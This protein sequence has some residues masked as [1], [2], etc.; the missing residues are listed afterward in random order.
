MGKLTYFISLMLLCCAFIVQTNDFGL[1][2]KYIKQKSTS[3]IFVTS[4]EQVQLFYVCND[5]S[6]NNVIKGKSAKLEIEYFT[7]LDCDD[8]KIYGGKLITENIDSLIKDSIK[9]RF[10]TNNYYIYSNKI[11]YIQKMIPCCYKKFNFKKDKYLI[12]EFD[13]GVS[14]TKSGPKKAI[15]LFQKKN[16]IWNYIRTIYSNN[17][18]NRFA[19]F[20]NDNKLD[21]Y[22]IEIGEYIDDFK[23]FN[24]NIEYYSIFDT[25]PYLIDVGFGKYDDN[26]K[27]YFKKAEK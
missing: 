10:D 21:F 20:N 8:L 24:L 27:L 26:N 15:I 14:F 2:N 13:F 23:A 1:M 6:K 7:D 16:E 11:S 25:K 9:F 19:D 12:F 5:I 18:E 17:N 22:E 4:E 3:S